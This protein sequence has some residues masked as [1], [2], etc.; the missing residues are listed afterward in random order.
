MSLLIVAAIVAGLE[1]QAAPATPASPPA[2]AR[3]TKSGLVCVEETPLGSRLGS[4]RV[5]T[6]AEDVD[7]NRR[8]DRDDIER[9]Q[10][11]TKLPGQ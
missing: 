11:L 2:R 6:R 5:C 4:R 10:R 3:A 8:E 9:A 1:P 7:R